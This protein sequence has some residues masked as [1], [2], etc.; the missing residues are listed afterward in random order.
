[1]I[2]LKKITLQEYIDLVDKS[3]YDFAMKYAFKFTE[4]VDEYSIG[5]FREKEFGFVKDW[6]YE[7]EHGLQMD[8]FLIMVI[9]LI[10]NIKLP[11]EPLDKLCRFFNYIAK[12]IKDI[13]DVE[14]VALSYDSTD[15]EISG[16]IDRF[17]DLGIYL[18]IRTIAITFGITIDQARKMKYND[19]FVELYTQ[20]QLTEYQNELRKQSEHKTTM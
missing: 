17:K 4:P 1:M 16:G 8:K 12:S 20:K 6:Q 19:A 14:K 9:D 3:K 2:Q 18:Q 5:D 13:S 11:N 10:P 7:F 15:A